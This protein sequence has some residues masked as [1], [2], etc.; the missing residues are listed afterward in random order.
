MTTTT[1]ADFGRKWSYRLIDSEGEV[2]SEK[3]FGDT[4]DAKL[5]ADS[6]NESLT[7]KPIRLQIYNDYGHW[8][9]VE[10]DR[11]KA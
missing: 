3:I 5:W 6:L 1:E 8:E 11:P 2:L 10:W 4:N 7:D 9:N